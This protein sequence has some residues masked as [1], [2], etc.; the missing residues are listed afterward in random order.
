MGVKNLNNHQEKLSNQLWMKIIS[1]TWKC[2]FLIKLMLQI[3]K[4]SG[5]L[6][7][8]KTKLSNNNHKDYKG[9]PNLHI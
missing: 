3:M 2:K 6:I 7:N 5:K 8:K 4:I 1:M 9:N